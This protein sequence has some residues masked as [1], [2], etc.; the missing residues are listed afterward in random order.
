MIFVKSI[1][2]LLKTG[3]WTIMELKSKNEKDVLFDLIK[4]NVGAMKKNECEQYLPDT[5]GCICPAMIFSHCPPEWNDNPALCPL[6]NQ[7]PNQK[8]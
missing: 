2:S 3:P 8:L 1:A 5:R 6:L 4:D 7:G